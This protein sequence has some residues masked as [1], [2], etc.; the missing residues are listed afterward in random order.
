MKVPE[1]IYVHVK[2]D[3]ITNTWN[4]TWIGVH[5]VEYIRKDVFI[6]KAFEFFGEH[7][8]EYIDVKNANCGTYINIDGDKLKEDFRKY[9][10]GE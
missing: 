10:E 6:E 7:L 4:S 2:G 5:D 1:K 3:K 9:M 8:W